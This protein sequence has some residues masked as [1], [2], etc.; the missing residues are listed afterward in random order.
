MRI[1]PALAGPLR[2]GARMLTRALLRRARTGSAEPARGRAS[3]GSAAG[4]RDGG[5]T[6][7]YAGDYVGVPPVEYTPVADDAA[8]PG[9]VVWAWVP[10]EEDH[11]QGKD[12]PVLVIGRD[13]ALLLALPLTSRDRTGDGD[14]S[15]RSGW[16]D[17]G[18][19]DWDRQGRPSEANLTR[20]L[21]LDAASVRRTGSALPRARFEAVAD[22]LRRRG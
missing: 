18:A 15:G 9:E 7:A 1:D 21:R 17:V 6:G 2:R 10:Y 20:I 19:G 5:P 4:R 11:S 3:S 16:V 14:A 12:R 13:G 22:A 8:D